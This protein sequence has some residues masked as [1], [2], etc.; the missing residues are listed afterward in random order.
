LR[1]DECS[2]VTAHPSTILDGLDHLYQG[3]YFRGDEYADYLGDK[4]IIQKN[5]RR[6]LKTVRRFVP[7]GSLV[8]VGCAYGFFLE[9]AQQHF[10]SFGYDVSEEAVEYAGSQLGV[11][12]KCQDFLSDSGVFPDSIDAITM[13]D[14]VEHLPNPRQFIQHSAQVLK[15]DGF[16]F[17]TTGDIESWVARRQGRKWRLIHPPTHLQYFSKVT[18]TRL[19]N[20]CG[21]DVVKVQYPVYWRSL[22]QILYG[23]FAVE[24]PDNPPSIYRILNKLTPGKLGV[25]L[26]T[27]DIMF[28]TAQKRPE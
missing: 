21:F 12:A 17:I 13:W 27:F 26:N 24:K 1:C 10:R 22:H 11:T 7:S 23:V 6:W 16:L 9:L 19:L 4:R 14:V 2:F 18:L 8:D 25:P 20:R 28:V 5:F 3:D 15:P